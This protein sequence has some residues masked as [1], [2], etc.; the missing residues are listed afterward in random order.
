MRL[1]APVGDFLL[2]SARPFYSPALRMRTTH[3]H[4]VRLR[5]VAPPASRLKYFKRS[6]SPLHVGVKRSLRSQSVSWHST[7][8]RSA[9]RVSRLSATLPTMCP[10]SSLM[11]QPDSDR[12]SPTSR[13]AESTQLSG[14]R[15]QVSTST[16][17]PFRLDLLSF[18][19]GE[20]R[21]R[22]CL[23]WI[24][25]RSNAVRRALCS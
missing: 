4:P 17:S 19:S 8:P 5:S 1:C 9:L 20:T 25:L 22:C 3:P 16:T 10:A 11:L 7:K 21:T 14:P 24:A 23:T 6:L 18:L 13:S 12:H 2:L 15:R